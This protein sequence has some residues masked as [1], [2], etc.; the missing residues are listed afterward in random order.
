MEDAWNFFPGIYVATVTGSGRIP[1]VSKELNRVGVTNFTLNR[2]I[3]PK[4]KTFENITLSCTDNHQQIYRDALQKGLPYIC[5][6]E[7]DVYFTDPP[8]EI[9][10]SLQKIAKFVNTPGWDFLYIG[11]FP[12]KIGAKMR[13]YPGIFK[14]ISW[15]THAY[16]ISNSGMQKMLEHTP[17]QMMQIARVGVPV[18]ANMMFKECGGIDTYIAYQTHRGKFESFCLYPMFVFQYSIPGWKTKA[19]AAEYMSMKL[20]FWPN[21]LAY[22][23]WVALWVVIYI[24][25]VY[26]RKRDRQYM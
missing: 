9:R 23:G 22:I 17:E 1:Q 13:N 8:K 24:I 16:V 19:Q 20:G 25:V 4:E 18:I 26:L 10:K 14:S 12:W 7:D 3:P 6:F 21:G 11:H 5:V 2:Q 15:C